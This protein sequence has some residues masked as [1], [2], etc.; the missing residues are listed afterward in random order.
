M[1]NA[2]EIQARD[3][4]ILHICVEEFQEVIRDSGLLGILHAD[5]QFV[6]IGR[7]QIEGQVI[8]VPH[9]LD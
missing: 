9:R 6:R 3:L 2:R 4:D 7:G 8:I 5:S 1:D